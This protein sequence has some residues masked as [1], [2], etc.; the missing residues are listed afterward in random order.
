MSENLKYFVNFSGDK[1]TFVPE[2]REVV[3][4]FDSSVLC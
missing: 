2:I 3:G 4:K 1:F